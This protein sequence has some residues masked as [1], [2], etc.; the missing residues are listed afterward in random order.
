[1]GLAPYGE[2][3]F[4][5]LILDK[6]ID[7]KK[8]GTFRLNMEYFDYATGLKM[9]NDKFSKLYFNQSKYIFKGKSTSIKLKSNKPLNNEIEEFIKSKKN[10]TDI[11]FAKNIIKTLND[12][13]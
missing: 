2:P 6:L 10:L 5:N 12:V 11:D 9:T 4:K 1:M 3:K 8:D 13:N 7:L